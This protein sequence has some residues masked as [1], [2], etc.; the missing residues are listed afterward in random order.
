MSHT[1]AAEKT[2]RTA[3]G[4]SVAAFVRFTALGGGMTL[5]ASAVIPVVALWMPWALANALITVASTAAATE[6][7][8]RVTFRHGRPDWRRHLQSA[9][10]IAGG[11]L[12]TTVAVTALQDLHPN[13]GT[14]LTQAVYLTASALVGIARFLILKLS[15]FAPAA[16]PTTN[17]RV[18]YGTAA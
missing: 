16:Q 14:L 8:G 18:A 17:L 15:V 11:W 1:I 13:A 2:A 7:H 5:L 9:L 12:V 6:L 10:T 4:G 3:K